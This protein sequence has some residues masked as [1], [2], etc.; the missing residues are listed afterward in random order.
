MAPEA[1]AFSNV[2]NDLNNQLIEFYSQLQRRQETL[3]PSYLTTLNCNVL[4]NISR[5]IV[6]VVPN[7]VP[8]LAIPQ[9]PKLT[10]DFSEP[11]P[12]IDLNFNIYP[13]LSGNESQSTV[14]ELVTIACE[15]W[16]F[17]DQIAS[18]TQG[19]AEFW[20][21]WGQATNRAAIQLE[22]DLMV[23]MR[24]A[25]QGTQSVHDFIPK[26][27]IFISIPTNLT[28]GLITAGPEFP[29]EGPIGEGPGGDFPEEGFPPEFA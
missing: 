1:Q 13:P 14:Y 26:P 25:R 7:E 29:G 23:A 11:G 20:Q 6:D 17:G 18:T 24:N 4:T 15:F 21:V 12:S 28:S 27:G 9:E 3:E 5:T 8:G 2:C 19:S 16:G 22:N 10:L